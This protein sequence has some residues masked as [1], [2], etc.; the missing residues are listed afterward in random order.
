MK[1]LP[2][3]AAT[4][5]ADA[6][7]IQ[8]DMAGRVRL[9]PLSEPPRRVAATDVA[10]QTRTGMTCAAVVVVEASTLELLQT[11]TIRQPTEFPYIPG[12]LSFREVPALLACFDRLNPAP[13]L[14][15]CDGQGIAHPR[16]L[17]LAAHL[18]LL[19]QLPTIGCAKSR[20]VG[21]YLEPAMEKGCRSSLLYKD[22]QIGEVVRTRRGVKPLFVSPGHLVSIADAT[23]MVLATTTRYR[24]PEPI[25]F[26]HQAAEKAKYPLEESSS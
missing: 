24:L 25:R 9:T 13:D 6:V 10:F 17:G 3:A 16:G 23:R 18:G 8:R 14:V 22:R 20:L 7:R 2:F 19:L 5:Y 11:V 21:E 4:D 1:H 26:A 12:L 15:I